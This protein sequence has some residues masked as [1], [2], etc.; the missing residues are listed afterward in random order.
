MNRTEPL[1]H[2]AIFVRDTSASLAFYRDVL[3][4]DV[5]ETMEMGGPDVARKFGLDNCKIRVTYLSAEGSAFGRVALFEVT[6]PR[7]PELPYPATSSVLLGQSI[8]VMD[9]PNIPEIHRAL[10]ARNTPFL[11]EPTTVPGTQGGTVHEYIFFDP[12]GVAIDLIHLEPDPG[13]TRI[14]FIA[15]AGAPRPG[16]TN[17][18]SPLLRVSIIVRDTASS[19]AVY[20]DI[21]GLTVVN[22]RQVTKAGNLLGVGD[23]TIDVTYLSSNDSRLGLIGLFEVKGVPVP[24]LMRPP[25]TSVN[26]GQVAMVMGTSGIRDIHAALV[27]HGSTLLCPPTTTMG[28]EGQITELIF[29]D[30]DGVAVHLVEVASR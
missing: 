16:S 17:R 20:R 22:Q 6:D 28:P 5:D 15:R 1:S 10:K 27:R 29:F 18:T 7:P 23:C 9:S 12:D 13:Q 24:E 25:T 14:D 3:G 4:M 30:P 2:A 19:L 21:L 8:L 26:R 11:S